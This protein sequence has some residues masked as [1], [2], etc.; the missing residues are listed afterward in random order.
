MINQLLNKNHYLLTI[1]LLDQLL[2]SSAARK[3]LD[4]LK[5]LY[6]NLQ[7]RHLLG[8]VEWDEYETDIAEIREALSRLGQQVDGVGKEQFIKEV[9]ITT[10]ILVLTPYKK[11]F[12]ELDDLFK[13]FAFTEATIAHWED[14]PGF[15][16][17]PILVFD[18]QDLL[19]ESY[20]NEQAVLKHEQLKLRKQRETLME[21]CIR[22]S[23]SLCLHYGNQLNWVSQNRQRVHAA[24]SKF[25]LFAKLKELV[26]FLERVKA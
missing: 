8:E 21:N 4:E 7:Q 19:D 24:N 3:Q 15:H 12:P 23:T 18:N 11:R 20:A 14:R 26:E 1:K 9:A 22:S 5:L 10:R 16:A 17:Y 25:S 6:N 13:K 2:E